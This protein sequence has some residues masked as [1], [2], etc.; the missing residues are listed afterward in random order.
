MLRIWS[1]FNQV[2]QK[3]TVVTLKK[4]L[5]KLLLFLLSSKFSIF[6]WKLRAI[7][8]EHRHIARNILNRKFPNRWFYEM[9]RSSNV[10]DFKLLR[11]CF[12]VCFLWWRGCG[13]GCQRQG[14]FTEELKS[15]VIYVCWLI[16]NNSF[17]FVT[18]W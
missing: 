18:Y 3:A 17:F 16:S 1:S 11:A 5:K 2:W 13:A 12:F 4:D 9:V 8:T 7:I 15:S 10:W 6:I 14:L